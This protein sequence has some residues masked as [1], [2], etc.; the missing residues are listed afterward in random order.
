[1]EHRKQILMLGTQARGGM[2]E[3]IN[4]YLSLNLKKYHINYIPTHLERN[5]VL[6]LHALI[7]SIVRSVP[8]FLHK[9]LRIVHI[10][11]SKKGSFFRKYFFLILCK[12]FKKKIILQT[13]GADFFEY[14]SSCNIISKCFIKHFFTVPDLVI[15]LSQQRGNEYSAIFKTNKISVVPNFVSVPKGM[16]KSDR[17]TRKIQ[18]LTL[19]R[20]G[21]RKG[22]GDLIKIFSKL[23]YENVI[24]KIGGDGDNGKFRKMINERGLKDYIKLLG[25]V[26]HEN[27][28]VLLENSDIFILPSYQEDL[29]MAILEAMSYGLPILST[30]VAGIPSLVEHGY[31]GYLVEPGDIDDCVDKLTELINDSRLRQK[32]GENSLQIIK[33]RF[34]K[35]IV[36]KQIQEVYDS[37]SQ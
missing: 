3:V 7:I 36:E 6:K 4:Q 37:L 29:P 30:N 35:S 21:D 14:Y 32:F 23:N 13:H 9:D 22:T 33:R 25:W 28:T 2:R 20:V 8:L 15:V 34:E 10:H 16:K 31:N 5:V 12:T 27:K 18:L 26:E 19:G 11:S 1:M 24:L 17:G